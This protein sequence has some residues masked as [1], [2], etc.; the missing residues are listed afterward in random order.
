MGVARNS[1]DF[2]QGHARLSRSLI[3]VADALFGESRVLIAT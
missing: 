3:P 1:S 2:L